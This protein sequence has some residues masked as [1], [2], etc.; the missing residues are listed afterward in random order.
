VSKYITHAKEPRQ[1]IDEALSQYEV[2]AKF[3]GMSGGRDSIAVTHWMMENVD[4]CKVFH[5]NTGIGIKRTREFV[6]DTCRD[7]GWPL[8]EIRAK[9]DCGQDFDEIVLKHGFPGPHG[10]TFMYN[11]LK[12]RCLLRLHREYKQRRGGKI[13]LATG[14]RYDESARRMRYAGREVNRQGGLIWVNPLY[15]FSASDR[16]RYIEE[17]SLPIN[18]ISATLGM[19]GECLCGAFAHKG[20]KEMVRLVDPETA[21]RLDALERKCLERGFTWGWE[22]APPAGGHNPDQQTMDFQPLCVGCEK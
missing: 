3:V 11:R 5:L 4:G 14:L 18:P 6:R 9:E 22:G 7:M 12:E 20:E 19:S 21:E 2:N 8:V 13:L 15:W 10:H 17:H 1:I 16:D